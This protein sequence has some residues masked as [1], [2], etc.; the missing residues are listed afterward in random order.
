MT[1]RGPSTPTS[2][3]ARTGPTSVSKLSRTSSWD[4]ARLAR[5]G[6]WLNTGEPGVESS[7]CA[8]GV[9]AMRESQGVGGRS[10]S[11]GLAG[12]RVGAAMGWVAILVCEL[13]ALLSSSM[14][15][16]SLPPDMAQLVWRMLCGGCG[17]GELRPQHQPS[18]K[19]SRAPSLPWTPGSMPA[20]R[21]A[22]SASTMAPADCRLPASP[23]RC[24][25]R[26]RTSATDACNLSASAEAAVCC[27]CARSASP[28]RRAHQ[29]SE[30]NA[31]L[32]SGDRERAG[33]IETHA[34][35]C[36]ARRFDTRSQATVL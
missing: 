2:L 35:P 1:W 8:G 15:G 23:R 28:L 17:C 34:C 20:C 9:S 26:P 27:S 5:A 30:P 21:A 7:A 16:G 4:P 12:T 29:P 36:L 19:G 18:V 10:S 6:A 22:M 32:Y 33:S 3:A 14:P 24:S 13:V 25:T 31:S 11:E